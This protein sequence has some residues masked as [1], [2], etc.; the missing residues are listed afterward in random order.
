MSQWTHRLCVECYDQR[1]PGAPARAIIGDPGTRC[2]ACGLGPARI[3]YRDNPKGY[4][5]CKFVHPDG[6]T[7]AGTG[8]PMSGTGRA[9]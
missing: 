6:T 4:R 2:C 3:P 5:Y 8:P 1:Q 7:A 9:G